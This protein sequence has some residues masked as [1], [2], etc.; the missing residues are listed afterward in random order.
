MADIIIRD[1]DDSVIA[2]LEARA[3]ATNQSLEEVV[4]SILSE[5]AQPSRDDAAAR[6]AEIRDNIRARTGGD[7]PLDATALIREDRD[8]R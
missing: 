6:A 2:R 1:L 3:H 7:V 5:A 4:S 8:T